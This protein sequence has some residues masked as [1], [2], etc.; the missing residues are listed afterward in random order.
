M[1]ASTP[2]QTADVVIVGAGFAGLAAARELTRAGLTSII[3]EARDRIGG[4]TWYRDSPLGRPLEFGGGF[5][6]W[7][8]PHVWADL[9]AYGIELEPVEEVDTVYWIAGGTLHRSPTAEYRALV[10]PG[11]AAL[12]EGAL[13]AFPRPHE[14]FPLTEQA[15]EAD[16]ISVP[17][18]IAQLG[19]SGDLAELLRT[20]WTLSFNGPTADA[21][22]AQILRHTALAGGAWQMRQEAANA[23]L[24]S[25]S[26]RSYVEKLAADTDAEIR[27]S[28][29]V[30]RIEHGDA[31]V[32]VHTDTGAPISA[33]HAIITVPLNILNSIEVS[34]PLSERKRA[35]GER[36][37]VS[38]GFKVW[39]RAKGDV[40][41]FI[42]FAP[43]TSPLTMTGYEY[44]ID[45]DTILLGFGPR[46][47]ELDLTD[48]RAVEAVVRQWL[49]DVELL[50]VD[51]HD[52][53]AD[54]LSGESWAMMR[55]GQ[56]D[57]LEDL[58]RPE[59]RVQLAGSDY[60]LGWNGHVDGAI[61]SARRAVRHIL[62]ES[63]VATA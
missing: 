46:S 30:K 5:F 4:R 53:T 40:G 32:V 15:R 2:P 57:D 52:W 13:A 61:E 7:S 63:L 21:S 3:V 11:Q 54:P 42:A 62:D 58:I 1:S 16:R 26:T 24:L 55:T 8:Q 25:G 9:V 51:A 48:V 41:R 10:G 35:A 56:L 27:L 23:Y 45:G 44:S 50:A 28:T 43:D 39:M 37:Q 59:G 60:A 17:E 19:F 29:T 20:H 47:G 6:H 33:R 31:G 22:W 18:R 34:P 14:V 36:G 49:P 12:A 38:E